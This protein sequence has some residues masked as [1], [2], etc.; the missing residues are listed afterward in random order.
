M[1]YTRLAL[2]DIDWA[3]AAH[4]HLATALRSVTVDTVGDLLH[5]AY[6]HSQT[7][8]GYTKFLNDAAPAHVSAVRD[9][10][11]RISQRLRTD[12]PGLAYAEYD[13]ISGLARRGQG[14]M[15][16]ATMGHAD[17]SNTLQDVLGLMVRMARPIPVHGEQVP[18]WWTDPQ[19]NAAPEADRAAYPYGE[20]NLG[21]AHGICGPMSLMALAHRAGHGTPGMLDAIRTMASWVM[22]KRIVGE[23]GTYWP[24]RVAFEDEIGKVGSR[25]ASVTPRSDWCY[26]AAGVARALYLAGR[27]LEDPTLIQVSVD[28][29]RSIFQ[30]PYGSA[31][32]P[33]ATVCHGRAGVLLAAVR[34]ASDTGHPALWEGADQMA[35]QLARSFDPTTAFGYRYLLS[36]NVNGPAVDEP[37]VLQGA[38][39]VALTLLSYA[40]ARSGNPTIAATWDG[41]LLMG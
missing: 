41:A 29:M 27:A 3:S 25:A 31:E 38:A 12:G 36:Q 13:V 11:N 23:Q 39:G 8:G 18:G 9:L 7:H 15:V 40:D 28:A 37:G 33:D 14:L 26:G 2:D 35:L 10:L 5:A 34:T 6:L 17:S 21:I 20:F 30:R 24:G 22:R 1:L 32:I 19:L 4:A 16:G